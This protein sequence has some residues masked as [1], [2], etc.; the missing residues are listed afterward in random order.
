M[1][2][3]YLQVAII[4]VI[5]MT[6]LMAVR[7]FF[8]W[9]ED[10]RLCSEGQWIRHGQPSEQAPT[11]GCILVSKKDAMPA[12][13]QIIADRVDNWYIPARYTCDANEE[14]PPL[15]IHNIH[16]DTRSLAL[17]I[18]DPDAPG[19]TRDH[20]LLANIPF[21]WETTKIIQ[22]TEKNAVVGKNSRGKTSR[23]APCPPNGV[24]RYFFKVYALDQ[25]LELK[26]WFTKNELLEAMAGHI[27]NQAELIWLYSSLPK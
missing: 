3:T 9:P 17:I 14:F 2:K 11:T 27:I 23:W 5:T 13:L 18:D 4:L 26:A 16:A 21:I 10:T 15:T 25:V 6:A 20:Y 8:W 1:R 7:V 19:E 22:A 12:T 24:H